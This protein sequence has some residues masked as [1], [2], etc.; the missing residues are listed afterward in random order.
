VGSAAITL[1]GPLR[2]LRT[3][4]LFLVALMRGYCKFDWYLLHIAIREGPVV[5]LLTVT[6]GGNHED[7]VEA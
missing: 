4:T 5:K 1:F 6:L 7:V 2:G 3:V